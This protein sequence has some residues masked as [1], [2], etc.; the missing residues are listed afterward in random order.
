[1]ANEILSLRLNTLHNVFF[2]LKLMANI[3]K[4]IGKG[5]FAKFKKEFLKNYKSWNYLLNPI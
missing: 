5:Q 1:M 3:R 4:A 2:Y